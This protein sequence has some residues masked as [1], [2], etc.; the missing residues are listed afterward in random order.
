[1]A[2]VQS[3][4][5]TYRHRHPEPTDIFLLI[6]VADSSLRIDRNLKLSIYARAG[7]VEYWILNVPN[8]LVEIY[9]DP[10]P[11]A[12]HYRTTLTA[13]PGETCA[14]AAFPDA[15]VAVDDLLG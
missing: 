3:P 7:I 9:R 4:P 12:G 13:R 1:M 6:E 10:D 14:P 8:T 11:V 5:T 15:V 2:L